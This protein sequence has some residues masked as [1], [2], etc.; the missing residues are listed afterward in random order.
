MG[1]SEEIKPTDGRRGNK[2]KKSIPIKPVPEGERSNK[3][4]LNQAKKSRKKAYAKRALKNV[5]G[6]EVAAFEAAAKKAKETGNYNMYKMLFDYAYEEDNTKQ[7]TT[8]NAPVI[9]FFGNNEIEKKVKDKIIDIT[10]NTL[11]E[12]RD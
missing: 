4:A 8:N 6:S 12:E 9:N 5:F 3:P 11:D 1:K 10:D 2:R 7:V